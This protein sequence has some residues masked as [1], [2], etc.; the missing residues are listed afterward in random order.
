[1][2]AAPPRLTLC[3]TVM[4]DFPGHAK[5]TLINKIYL[6]SIVATGLQGNAA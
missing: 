3:T 6:A 2:R 5:K 4:V 1:L